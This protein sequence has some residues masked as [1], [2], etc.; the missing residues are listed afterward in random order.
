MDLWVEIQICLKLRLRTSKLWELH[1][2]QNWLLSIN[3]THSLSKFLGRPH[4]LLQI[5]ALISKRMTEIF[6]PQIQIWNIS[7]FCSAILLFPLNVGKN[8]KNFAEAFMERWA[9][10]YSFLNS[11]LYFTFQ[12]MVVTGRLSYFSV[13]GD[14]EDTFREQAETGKQITEWVNWEVIVV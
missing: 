8:I 6:F 11:T 7:T 13:N 9:Q 3:W 14:W 10:F 5:I 1:T 12:L 2:S 4:I